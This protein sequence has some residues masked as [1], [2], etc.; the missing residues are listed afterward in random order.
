MLAAAPFADPWRFQSN[1]EVY[2]LVAFLIGAAAVFIAAVL[3]SP[4]TRGRLDTA[5][6]VGE[7]QQA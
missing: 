2:L 4:E 3:C 7:R 5:A 1:V 6:P